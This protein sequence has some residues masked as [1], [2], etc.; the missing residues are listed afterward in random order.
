MIYKATTSLRARLLKLPETGM[1]YQIISAPVIGQMQ[2]RTFIIYNA[3]LLLTLKNEEFFLADKEKIVEEGL[4]KIK[5]D[6]PSIALGKLTVLDKNLSHVVVGE[7]TP[8]PIGAKDNPEE[9]AEG[10]EVFVRMS[11]YTK[12][13]RVD[14]KTKNL[15]KGSFATTLVDFE[16]ARKENANL[17]DRYALPNDLE[18]EVAFHIQAE[19]GDRFR[20]GKVQPAFG[21]SGGGIEILVT[22][23]TAP[24][25]LKNEENL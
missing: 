24:N 23:N 11:P 1:G 12:D 17:I 8:S 20:K 18:P 25:S 13:N 10:G 2:E 16:A 3:T 22:S 14:K 21:H 15:L 9:K 5:K 19:K 6:A 4:K 7:E